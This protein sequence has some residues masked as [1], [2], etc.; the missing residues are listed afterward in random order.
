[1]KGQNLCVR[2]SSNIG[3]NW[4]GDV[5]KVE[6]AAVS[7][8]IEEGQVYAFMTNGGKGERDRN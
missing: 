1:M 5:T 7:V 4:H 2:V 6:G 3:L 8:S